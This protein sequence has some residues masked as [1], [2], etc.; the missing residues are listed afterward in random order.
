MINYPIEKKI[1]DSISAYCK[2]LCNDQK[3]IG[4][5]ISLA[6]KL[7]SLATIGL[8]TSQ[9]K[10]IYDCLTDKPKDTKT[11]AQETKISHIQVINQLRNINKTTQLI[12]FG[13][14]GRNKLWSKT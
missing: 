9:Q 7:S 12:S 1:Y 13:I 11:I 8:L 14:E 5:P 3:Y 6:Q 10:K 2:G 4:N